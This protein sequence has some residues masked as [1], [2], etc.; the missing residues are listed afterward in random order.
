MTRIEIE[1]LL[2]LPGVGDE[3]RAQLK[4]L[5]NATARHF[6]VVQETG[7]AAAIR[8]WETAKAALERYARE[9]EVRTGPADPP[10]S[11]RVE[12]V[13]WLQGQGWKIK[14]TK[15]YQDAASGLLR[16]QPDG[17]VLRADAADYAVRVGLRRVSDPLDTVDELHAEKSRAEIDRLKKQV[18]LLTLDLEQKRGLWVMRSEV[19]TDLAVRVAV[20][21]SGFCQMVRMRAIEWAAAIGGNTRLERHLYDLIV[22]EYEELLDRYARGVEVR[23][24]GDGAEESAEAELA[25]ALGGE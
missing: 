16:V 19:E 18:E 13:K 6:A 4:G 3:E 10:F 8:D 17:S 15:L 20:L 11:S 7:S 12:V 14:K 5:Y 21:K 23:V 24:S 25:E 1:R 22:A 9:V 2:A